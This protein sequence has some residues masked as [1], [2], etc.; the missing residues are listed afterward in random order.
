MGDNFL[1]AIVPNFEGEQTGAGH[2]GKKPAPTNA[3]PSFSPALEKRD[4]NIL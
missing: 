3:T 1:A 4:W 2:S